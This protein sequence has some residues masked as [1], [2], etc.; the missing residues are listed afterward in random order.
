MHES[1][2]IAAHK[3]R[4]HIAKHLPGNENAGAPRERFS[5]PAAAR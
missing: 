4:L 1:G 3:G 2:R 5:L